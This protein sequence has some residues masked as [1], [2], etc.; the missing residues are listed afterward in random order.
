MVET[1]EERGDDAPE[2]LQA[3]GT[4]IEKLEEEYPQSYE[5][6]VEPL[7]PELPDTLGVP[8]APRVPLANDFRAVP[9]PPDPPFPALPGNPAVPQHSTQA[10]PTLRLLFPTWGLGLD[11][12]QRARV[13]AKWDRNDV[14]IPAHAEMLTVVSFVIVDNGTRLRKEAGLPPSTLFG[15]LGLGPSKSLFVIAGY[16]P[17][18][19][20]RATADEAPRRIAR[21]PEVELS[22]GEDLVIC[23][24]G[25]TVENSVFMLPLSVRYRRRTD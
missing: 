16:E 3:V 18:R 1:M 20:L 14:H 21:P 8:S 7:I 15:L 19:D 2:F 9:E 17:E 11:A 24:T 5:I 23:L 12:R 10:V 4:A 13:Q 22:D 6:L 25:D